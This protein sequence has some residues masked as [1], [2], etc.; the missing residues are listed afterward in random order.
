MGFRRGNTRRGLVRH[1][2]DPAGGDRSDR[3]P[4][5]AGH[6]AGR[7]PSAGV[8]A[9]VGR[10]G[11]GL[12][13]LGRC[14]RHVRLRAARP[15]GGG[16]GD[17]GIARSPHA[18]P[19]AVVVDR[20]MYGDRSDPARVA[21]R[22]GEQLTSGMDSGLAGVVAAVRHA[23]RMPYVAVSARGEVVAADGTRPPGELGSVPL[24]YGGEPVGEVLVGLRPGERALDA[25]DRRVLAVVA[26]LEGRGTRE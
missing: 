14:A 21:S 26:Y 19:A 7:V 6:P 23:L 18:A 24:I 17:R 12:H 15:L 3:P 25:A 11:G 4:P 5:T 13:R 20:A 2:A 22:V 9:A 16:D 1:P 10:R 8:A